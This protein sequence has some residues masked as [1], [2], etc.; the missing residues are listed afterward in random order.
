MIFLILGA[1]LTLLSLV[2]S[3]FLTDRS[4]WRKV[5]LGV[6]ISGAILSFV[7]GYKSRE[8]ADDLQG[9]LTALTEKSRPR[10]LSPAAQERIITRL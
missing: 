5:V 3:Y 8:R 2:I 6:G 7:L 1:V 10:T 9:Q 4:P